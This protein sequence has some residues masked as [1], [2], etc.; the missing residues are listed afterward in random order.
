MKL[1]ELELNELQ[2]DLIKGNLVNRV[3][4]KA[5]DQIANEV[6]KERRAEVVSEIKIDRDELREWV[7]NKLADRI[8][9]EWGDKTYGR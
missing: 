2:H 6:V 1:S 4:Y 5:T 3:L 9:D 7:L 8:I